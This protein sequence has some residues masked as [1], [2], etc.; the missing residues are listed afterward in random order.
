MA[1]AFLA[2]KVTLAIHA[3][4]PGHR[5]LFLSCEPLVQIPDAKR[6]RVQRNFRLARQTPLLVRQPQS[7]SRWASTG[8]I[9]AHQ[10]TGIPRLHNSY[11]IDRPS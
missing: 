10:R 7:L 2:E 11:V 9:A 5:E 3:E 4:S 6:V 1:G 8:S